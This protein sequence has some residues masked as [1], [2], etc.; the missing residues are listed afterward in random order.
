MALL[1][2]AA[3]HVASTLS[4]SMFLFYVVSTREDQQIIAMPLLLYTIAIALGVSIFLLF[5]TVRI[6]LVVRRIARQ[7][8]VLVAQLNFNHKLQHGVLFKARETASVKMI[9]IVVT[10]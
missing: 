9:G 4:A 7:N 8:A 2:A 5:A 6:F 10:V 3:W 1:V